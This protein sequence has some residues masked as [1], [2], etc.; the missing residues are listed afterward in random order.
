[1]DDIKVYIKENNTHII[2]HYRTVKD[3]NGIDV[4]VFDRIETV[5]LDSLI[6]QR[7]ELQS[8][9]DTIKKGAR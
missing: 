1:M 4:T 3:I 5:D 7:D 2:K 6:A 9:I 8:K